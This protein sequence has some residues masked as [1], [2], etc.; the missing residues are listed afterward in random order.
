MEQN[1]NP[2]H[3]ADCRKGE[4]G[5]IMAKTTCGG[6]PI[7]G[8]LAISPEKTIAVLIDE[9]EFSH[10]KLDR[11]EDGLRGA[12]H[13]PWGK[14]DTLALATLS[15]IAELTDRSIP[16]IELGS[17]YNLGKVPSLILDN[18]GRACAVEATRC[19][20]DL[21]HGN[22][23][24]DVKLYSTATQWYQVL[25]T[26]IAKKKIEGRNDAASTIVRIG[27]RRK[28]K[29]DIDVFVLSVHEK[30]GNRIDVA[31]S[32]QS[33]KRITIAVTI[34][35][36]SMQEDLLEMQSLNHARLSERN[37]S[38]A[39]NR[40]NRIIYRES[41]DAPI[42]TNHVSDALDSLFA[43]NHRVV[44]FSMTIVTIGGRNLIINANRPETVLDLRRFLKALTANPRIIE[45][46]LLL[47]GDGDNFDA[48]WIAAPEGNAKNDAAPQPLAQNV[49]FSRTENESV[50]TITRKA[51]KRMAGAFSF[52]EILAEIKDI[53][54]KNGEDD[55][56]TQSAIRGELFRLTRKG[57][58]ERKTNRT[59]PYRKV[60]ADA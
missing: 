32:M 53:A 10:L 56:V 12:L 37:H 42:R 34:S 59:E 47:S 51:M 5:E 17:G 36:K 43:E 58:L 14:Y 9:A 38:V 29:I 13:R 35:E 18:D 20:N 41:I 40:A 46:S 52:K 57:I 39:E 33:A 8:L 7:E 44:D 25:A 24:I 30:K 4:H 2:L 50:A 49:S 27:E 16:N 23:S 28:N 19:R 1:N 21:Q 54:R 6:K 26:P 3:R 60:L 48:S 55:G 45:F 15:V 11:T 22:N 31:K